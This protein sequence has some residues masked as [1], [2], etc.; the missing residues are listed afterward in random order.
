MGSTVNN[1]RL[2]IQNKERQ[3]KLGVKKWIELIGWDET[4]KQIKKKVFGTSLAD[5]VDV[6]MQ[7]AERGD[8]GVNQLA[9]AVEN[10]CTVVRS[11]RYFGLPDNNGNHD[12]YP[13]LKERTLTAGR[14]VT[15]GGKRMQVYLD[16][17]SI[18]LAKQLG[19]DNLS[20]GIRLA[21]RKAC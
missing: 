1:Y 9:G 16:D 11:D 17:E 19:N 21:L 2:T 4:G 8:T 14:P 18:A 12:D 13:E 5:A 15:I 3:N 20:E 6:M 7:M 10:L